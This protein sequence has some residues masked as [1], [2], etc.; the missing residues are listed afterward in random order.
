MKGFKTWI[1]VTAILLFC[2]S[3]ASAFSVSS[4]SI[5]PSGSLIPDTPVTV[6]FKVDTSGFSSGSDLQFFTELESP[7]WTYTIS[8]N[9]VDNLRPS[10]GGKTLTI[11]GFELAYKPGDLVDLRATLEGKAPT[12]T[13]TAD[14]IIIRIQEM[15]TNGAAIAATKV[16]RT[17][18]VI[19]IGEVPIVIAERDTELQTY[20]THIDEKA[21]LGIDISAADAKYNEAK[22]KID[23]ARARPKTQYAEALADLTA[24]QTSIS[25]GEKALDRAWAETEVAAAQIPI[26]NVDGVIAWFKGNKTTADDQQL[27]AIITK[28]EVAVSYISTANDQIASGE[29]S[30]ARSKALDAFK[31]GNESYN[32]ALARQKILMSGWSFSFPQIPIPGG[33][34]IVIGVVVVILVAVGIIIYRKR[35]RW[36]ELG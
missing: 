27:T 29:Y 4:V 23:S 18:K 20:R 7:K 28:R 32:D 2:I 35:S 25:A 31:K 13:Q 19:N 12:V 36:D 21:V 1:I 33:I 16:E 30:Q 34:F 15:G 10:M 17:A 11:S 9:G 8:V 26:N 6:S 5:D 22:Q 24:A 3:A 14:K